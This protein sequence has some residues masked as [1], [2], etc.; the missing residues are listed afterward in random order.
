[1]R[2]ARTVIPLMLAV[3]VVGSASGRPN[4][5]AAPMPAVPGEILV[6]FEPDVGARKQNELLR[7]AGATREQHFAPIRS[8][9]VSVS[10]GDVGQTIRRLERDPSVA[11]AEPNYVVSA[12]S[13]GSTPNDPS[14]HQLWG[15]DNFGQTVNWVTGT[16]DADI[17]AKEAWSV[18]TGSPNVTVAVIDTGV[19]MSHPD[20]AA[21]IWV[22]E[23]E[24]CAG[25]RTN[26]AD[27]DGNG[28]VDDWR[29]WDFVNEDNNPTDDHGHGTHVAGTIAAAGNNGVG[30][31]GV[32]WSAKLM[33]LKF[34]SASGSG[35]V[36]DAIEAILYADAQGVP[37]LNNSWGGEDFS[38][39]L[40]D[41]IELTD[42]SGALFVAAAGNDFTNTDASPTYPSGFVVPN[43]LSVGSSDA[44]DRKSWFSNYGATS[45]D[46]SAPGSN[47]LS[48]WPGG[49]YR[50]QDGTSMAAPHVAGAAAL[51]KAAQPGTSG[52][53]L[54]ALLLRTAD[55]VAALAGTSRTGARLN[56]DRAARCSDQPRAWIDSP[57]PG[58]EANAGEPLAIRVLAANC[59]AP[60]G[61][62]VAATVN[63][64][65]LELA[66][67]GDGAY[68]TSLT[69][70]AGPV[71]IAVTATSGGSTDSQTSAGMAIENYAIT[72]GG[73][74]VTITT[75]AA[76]EN[77]RLHFGGSAGQRVALRLN[78]VTIGTS[79]CC[80]TRISIA[81]PDGTS[82]VTPMPFGTTGGFI[83]TRTLPL[84]GE[85]TILVDPQ[86]SDTGS[87]TLTLYD[88]PPDHTGSI[89]VG[90]PSVLAGTTT[91][92]QNALVTFDGTAGRRI[93]L[94]LEQVSIGTSGCCSARVS[95]TRPDGATLVFAT[96]FGTTGAFVDTRTL[97]ISGLYT[98]LLDPQ[99][100]DV[101]SASLTLYD[102][103]PDATASIAPGGAPVTVSMGPVP[104]QNALVGFSGVAGRR[105]ALTMG[106]VTIGTSSCCSAR[107]SIAKPDGSMLVAATPVG[108]NGGFLDTRALPA[109]GPYTILVD[110]QGVDLGSL[111]LTLHDVPLDLTGTIA[112]GGPPVSLM[113]GPAPGQNARLT[114]SGT[115]GQRISL[116][117][118]D[119]TIGGSTC[120][121]ASVSLLRP[122]GSYLVPPG[123]VGTNGRTITAT[124][125]TT[126]THSLTVDPQAANTGG[127]TLLLTAS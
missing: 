30:I 41:A 29:G 123:L 101:G 56:V 52:A 113:L 98:I 54:K 125:S 73:A 36:A 87:M 38:Q 116:R 12:S 91:A 44:F 1:M 74:P 126:G 90:G 53:G 102:V 82:L 2:I 107:V 3:L 66:A 99:G 112:I 61:A 75:H 104:G 45:V 60:G 20:L 97:P 108:R 43:V 24:N 121:G 5:A 64:A 46:L 111:T 59:A 22:N 58:F 68:T 79:G 83:D 8:T 84:D 47:I 86:G 80:S 50:F 117:L 81:K 67:R 57:A 88:V 127:I 6:G 120:C 118:S 15:L 32:T 63:G 35:S 72:P 34:L 124:L 77:A 94:R 40:L 119:V 31:A 51:V 78:G 11:F 9:L 105:I 106:D 70:A 76:G 115:A 85:Y 100:A 28:F 109:S 4:P 55:P 21:N 42:A 39:A 23:G 122:D 93:S 92:G 48:T 89:T 62:S 110:P 96:P 19:D 7:A 17:D 26:G 95:I 18:S 65:P 33:P 71:T 10:A 13:H 14:V 49:T 69:P 37:I 16:A 25:C 27:D 114:F 103:P